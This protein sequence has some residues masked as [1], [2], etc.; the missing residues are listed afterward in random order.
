VLYNTSVYSTGDIIETFTYRTGIG[1][2][3]YGLAAAIGL[4]QS[5]VGVA[6]VLFTNFL[7]KRFNQSGLF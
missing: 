2:T 5:V 3:R 6:L 4:F 1:Q 7:V